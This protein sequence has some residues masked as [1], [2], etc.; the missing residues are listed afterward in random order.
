MTAS[1]PRAAVRALVVALA[2][3]ISLACAPV[4][5][6]AAGAS[7][8]DSRAAVS[9]PRD[10]ASEQVSAG[11]E[12][13]A[14]GCRKSGKAVQQSVPSVRACSD[15]GVVPYAVRD[16]RA[17]GATADSG[18]ATAQGRTPPGPDIARLPVLRL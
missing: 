4:A 15:Q 16:A 7:A 1:L 3:L 12:R 2:A 10:A 5:Q 11:D 6:S 9:A 8:A 18:A 13:D 14:P 17:G